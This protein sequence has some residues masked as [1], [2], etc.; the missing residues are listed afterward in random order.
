MVLVVDAATADRVLGVLPGAR[1]IGELVAAD[2]VRVR[3]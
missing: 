2:G 1:V 3:I